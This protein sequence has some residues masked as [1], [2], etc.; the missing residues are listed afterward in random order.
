MSSV[1]VPS[2]QCMLESILLPQYLD[3]LTNNGYD[4]LH[5]CAMLTSSDLDRIGISPPG[6][7]RRI[8]STLA[9]LHL[10]PESKSIESAE[11]PVVDTLPVAL[12]NTTSTHTS[13]EHIPAEA[14]A[15]GSPSVNLSN[16]SYCSN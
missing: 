8:L 5:K 4:T 10:E 2:L 15:T 9:L 11:L 14:A 6:H 13:E 7:K 16:I 12:H 3:M 1:P